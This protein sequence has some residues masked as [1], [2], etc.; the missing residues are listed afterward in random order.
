MNFFKIIYISKNNPLHRQLGF[1]KAF[2]EINRDFLLCLGFALF[3]I[4]AMSIPYIAFSAPS[5]FSTSS[6][7]LPKPKFNP[8]QTNKNE[9]LN[10]LRL[11]QLRQKQE[12]SSVEDSLKKNLKETSKL[13]LK[14]D[15]IAANQKMSSVAESMT[16][17]DQRRSELL[18]RREFIYQ[19]IL[20]LDSKWNGQSLKP[21]LE[22]ALLDLALGDLTHPQGSSEIWKFNTYL[23]MVIR[24]VSEPH[25]DL[26]GLI[27]SYML[28]ANVINPK[29]PVQFLSS[30]NYSNSGES[31][32]ARPVERDQLGD[33][34]EH[35]MRELKIIEPTPVGKSRLQQASEAKTSEVKSS[36]TPLP[37][38]SLNILKKIGS[39]AVA[40]EAVP[41][42]HEPAAPINLPAS[43]SIS[44]DKIQNEIPQQEETKFE[45]IYISPRLKA[46]NYFGR[47]QGSFEKR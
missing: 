21:F 6:P 42:S 47:A 14:G 26:L 5:S 30:R 41:A 33:Y 45:Q 39:G 35:R 12:I 27:E 36:T 17:N 24:E 40:T 23:S 37:N 25:E 8:P 22:N 2:E 1:T 32:S 11:L 7:S 28:F 15:L 4:F 46:I 20:L 38:S 44:P 9:I 16:L 19:L 29:N 10:R 13:S 43:N 34:V 31:V 18:A 3:N